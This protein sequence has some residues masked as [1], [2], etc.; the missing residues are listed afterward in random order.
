MEKSC[1]ID[2]QQQ[3]LHIIEDISRILLIS[4]NGYSDAEYDTL[5]R[6]AGYLIGEIYM[7][8]LHKIY[9][10]YPDLDHL[11]DK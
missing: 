11:K 6:T 9:I 3:V 10:I 8:I 4:K 1:A 2:V 5:K 7:Q